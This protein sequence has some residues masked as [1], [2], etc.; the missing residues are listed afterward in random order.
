MAE[1]KVNASQARARL[2][3][4]LEEVEQSGRPVT[5]LRRGVPRAV[6]V[7]Y[8]QFQRR[9]QSPR[10][11]PWRLAG[12]LRAHSRLDIDDAISKTRNSM[13]RSMSRRLR[14]KRRDLAG[15]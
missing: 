4:L 5:I 13:R 12:S 6:I 8:E 14:G 9:F 2:P 3:A 15:R 1:R 7:S 10:E 11:R